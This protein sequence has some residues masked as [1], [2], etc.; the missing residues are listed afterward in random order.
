MNG[1]RHLRVKDPGNTRHLKT[2]SNG[3]RMNGSS[4]LVNESKERE[5]TK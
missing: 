2:A 3:D 4:R 5:P 1:H